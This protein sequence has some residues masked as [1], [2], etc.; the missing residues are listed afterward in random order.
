[1]AKAIGPQNTVG[2][3]GIMPSTVETAVSRIGRK[4]DIARLDH[5]VPDA[6]PSRA[7][8][9]DLVDQDHRVADD[10]ADQRENAEDRDEAER[11][12]GQQQR[13]DD[14][15]QAERHHAEHQEQPLE[16]LQLDHQDRQH[17]EQHQRHHGEDRGLRL[18][19]LLD[20]AADRDR[21]SRAAASRVQLGDRRRE[22]S[23]TTVAGSDAA[24]PR[25]PAR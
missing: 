8:G 21:G 18:G 15:D 6:L 12:A 3:I 24:A 2:A 4:R 5:R 1:M 13:R 16:A 20:R 10:H 25:R 17:E 11:P 14:A 9:L 22:R 19:A 7:L 23:T